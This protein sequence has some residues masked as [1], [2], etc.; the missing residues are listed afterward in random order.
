MRV[1]SEEELANQLSSL[2]VANPRVIASGNWAAPVRALEILEANLESYR[3][4]V[5]NLRYELTARPTVRFESP[6]VGA[7]MRGTD[8]LDYIPTRLSLIPL[9]FPIS[10]QPD[11]M[12]L[13]TSTPRSGKLSLGIEVN[14]LPAAL[15]AARARGALV[16]A[17]IN[18]RMPYTFGDSEISTDMIDVAIEV[19]EPMQVA[20]H[21]S[22]DDRKHQIG[23]YIAGLVPDG[24][25]LQ[26]GIG[27]IPDAAVGR[28]VERRGLKIWSEMISDGVFALEKAGA[29]DPDQPI[30]TSFL[31]GSEEF[32]QWLDGNPRVRLC[33]SE[34]TNDPGKIALNPMMMSINAALEIDLFA[35]ANASFVRGRLFSGFG[36]ATDFLVGAIHSPGGRAVIGLP[37]WHDKSK[38]SCVVPLLNV[39]ATSFQHSVV[40][41]DQGC[42]HIFGH[43]QRDQARLLIEKAAAPEARDELW[44]AAEKLGLADGQSHVRFEDPK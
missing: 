5:M 2:P 31:A 36:G 15:E 21:H 43:T 27:A 29:L 37:S 30:V 7:G 19:D 34:T 42:A 6:F 23:E 24:A 17:Q 33:R 26:L 12:L 22:S 1:I 8:R 4:F 16:V 41:T 38:T 25:T 40:V 28:L 35:Q 10:H 20:A 3:L 11:V 13:H 9:L 14:I 18:P 44:A 32:Y 39:P